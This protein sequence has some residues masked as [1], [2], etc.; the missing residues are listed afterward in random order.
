MKIGDLINSLK[1][2]DPQM[3]VWVAGADSCGY[4][5]ICYIHVPPNSDK[6]DDFLVIEGG[7]GE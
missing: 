1:E 4:S 2:Y 3:E 5:E 6:S 7:Q